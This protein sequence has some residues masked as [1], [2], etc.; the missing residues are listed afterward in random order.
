MAEPAEAG[1]GMIVPKHP[2]TVGA[3]NFL[4]MRNDEVKA[5]ETP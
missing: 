5:V 2:A 3:L 1:G 4:W